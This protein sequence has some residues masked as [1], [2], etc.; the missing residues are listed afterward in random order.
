MA[1]VRKHE[2]EV[3]KLQE[4]LERVEGKDIINAVVDGDHDFSRVVC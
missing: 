3:R 4:E 1:D 2:E